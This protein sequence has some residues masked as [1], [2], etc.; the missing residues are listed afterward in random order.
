MKLFIY[1]TLFLSFVL[2]IL[3]K[4]TIGS[5]IQSI[6]K[7]IDNYFSNKNVI[8][9]KD[10]LR[11]EMHSAIEKENYINK[12]DAILINKF[13]TKIKNELKTEQ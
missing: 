5:V 7:K 10:K 3:F 6:E 1:K 13:I 8:F 12:E 11:K 2:L 9:L 4:I